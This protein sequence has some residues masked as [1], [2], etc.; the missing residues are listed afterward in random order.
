MY[1]V[2]NKRSRRIGSVILS[3]I[4]VLTAFTATWV[5]ADDSPL[6]ITTTSLP[7]G[8]AGEKYPGVQLQATGG[9]GEGY[10]FY[11]QKGRLYAGIAE[12]WVEG[13]DG[14]IS[15]TPT[16]GGLSYVTF[17]VMDSE[18]NSATKRLSLSISYKNVGFTVSNY[19]YTYDGEPHTATV[20]ITDPQLRS[21]VGDNYTVLFGGEPSQTSS[22]LYSIQV[23][24]SKAGY[25][26][27]SINTPLTILR[28]EASAISLSSQTV[29]YDGRQHELVPTVTL[30]GETLTPEQLEE[31]A[32]SV[33]VTY[34]GTGATNYPASETAPVSAGTYRVTA[35][36]SSPGYT[37]RTANATLTINAPRIDFE[38]SGDMECDYDGNNHALTVN[39]V[40]SEGEQI[41]EYVVTYDDLSTI[42]TEE[43][44][45]V[46]NA[47]T[48]GLNISFPDGNHAVGN[49]THTSGNENATILTI[50]PITVDFNV[51]GN[52][53]RYNGHDQTAEVTPIVRED[54]ETPSFTV[55]Y[56]DTATEEV[57]ELAAV[58][59]PGAYDINVRLTSRNYEVGTLSASTMV[60]NGWS[61]DFDIT[62]TEWVYDAK[63]HKASV[64]PAD[65]EITADD[66]T[67][68][69]DNVS[70][71]DTETDSEVTNA[72]TY[73]INITLKDEN[74]KI[75]EVPDVFL[76]IEKRPVNFEVTGN[77]VQYDG[78]PHSASVMPVIS[79]QE[80]GETDTEHTYTYDV[81][82][83]DLSTE[84]IV[85]TEKEV[86]GVGKY[87]INIAVTDDNHKLGNISGSA[88]F[89]I[90]PILVDFTVSE[91]KVT[92]DG[93]SH[94][95]EVKP[96]LKEGQSESDIPEFT[97]T[98][99][100]QATSDVAETDAAVTD[101]GIY[102]I[103]IEF[104]DKSYAAG[105]IGGAVFV[106]EPKPVDFVVTDN[107]VV[108]DGEFH[109]AALTCGEEGFNEGTDYTVS[110]DDK[111]T[112]DVE[113]YDEVS[114]I[115]QYKINVEFKDGNYKCG[116]LDNDT[117]TVTPK[118]VRFAISETRQE[119]DGNSHKAKIEAVSEDGVPLHDAPEYIVTYDNKATEDSEEKDESVTD[120]G[121]YSINIEFTGENGGIY[122][123]EI[124][125]GSTL[126]TIAPKPI[127]FEIKNNVYP[128][129]G[130]AHKASVEAISDQGSIPAVKVT[131]DNAA[132]EEV[133]A[134]AEAV[135]IGKYN[136]N[137][138]IEDNNYTAVS[139]DETVLY[140]NRRSVIFA[141]S[142]T[143]KEYN[144]SAQQ[145]A[146]TLAE[147]QNIEDIPAFT[148][149]Y[150]DLAT[151]EM[152][153]T[154]T[155][156][157]DAGIYGISVVFGGE[158]AGEYA[159]VF[160][161]Y[162]TAENP[163]PVFTI[164]P[165]AVKVIITGTE[166]TY[167]GAEHEATV[168][169][170]DGQ[171][172]VPAFTVT[173][174]N[175]ATDETETLV[176]VSEIGVYTI[177]IDFG[178]GNYIAVSENE[179]DFVLT[180]SHKFVV[181]TVSGAT[182]TYS[183]SAQQADVTRKTAESEDISAIPDYSIIY[184]NS[185]TE[186]IEK[187]EAVTDAG[188][189]NIRVE[190]AGDNAGEY[191]AVFEGDGV[192][193]GEAVFTVNPVEVR[194]NISDTEYTYDGAEHRATI[195]L[196]EGQDPESIPAYSVTYDNR[197]TEEK[198]AL[199][200]A[201]EIGV[202]DIDID[203][204]SGNYKA[205]SA[206]GSEFVLVIS[207]KTA[208]FTVSEATAIYSGE[209]KTASVVLK[210]EAGE[211]AANIPEYVI[212][213][214]N[215]A[216][217]ET[218]NDAAVTDAGIYGIN[219]IFTGEGS[220]EYA[221]VF[222]GEGVTD[223]HAVFTVNPAE[224]KFTVTNA[225]YLYDG[226]EHRADV[227][228][229]DGQD[230]ENIPAYTV[231]YDNRA[232]TETETLESVRE[233]GIYNINIDFGNGNYRAV[234]DSGKELVLVISR[235]SFVF[236]VSGATVTYNGEARTAS[237]M[238]K[239]EEGQETS[240]IPEYI[241]TY[242]N[243]ATTDA[244]EEDVSV[245][246]AGI[247]GINI[248]FTGE[249][250]SEY[251][252]SFEGDGVT[253]GEAVFTIDPAE[254]R[255]D[256]TGTEY[257]YD[258][259]GHS[260]SVTLAEGQEGVPTEFKVT[261]DNRETPETEALDAVTEIGV[262]DINIDLGSS[263]YKAAAGDG[264]E[265]VLVIKHKAA[266]FTVS[267]TTVTYNGEARTASVVLKEGQ[268]SADVPEYVITYD[269]LATGDIAET[270]ASATDAGIY[271][272]NVIFT[273]EGGDEYAAL[274]EGEGVIGGQAVFTVNPVEIM[275]A[276]TN[277]EYIYDREAHTADVVIAEGQDS[278]NVPQH[279]VTYDDKATEEVETL[280][281]VTNAGSYEIKISLGIN[282]RAVL[283]E[284]SAETLTI[285]PKSV[286]M[287]I[288]GNN[289]SMETEMP[290]YAAV[291]TPDDENF[292]KYTVTYTETSE[293]GAS[294]DGSVSTSGEYRI[295]INSDDKNYTAVIEE[296]QN[297]LFT[298]EYSNAVH[299]TVSGN[300]ANF[301]PETA[302]YGA[303]VT[304]SVDG[305]DGYTVSYYNVKDGEEAAELTEIT[306]PG[307]YNIEIKVTNEDHKLGNIKM[308]DGGEQV[309]VLSNPVTVTLGNGNS[310]GAQLMEDGGEQALDEFK[311][312]RM[313]NG[314]YHGL[315]AWEEGKDIDSDLS[316][317]FIFPWIFEMGSLDEVRAQIAAEIS[318]LAFDAVYADGSDAVSAFTVK[319]DGKDAGEWTDSVGY[320]SSGIYD[321]EYSYYDEY[322][323]KT[324]VAASRKI[325]V[326]ASQ[327]GDV[328]R[329]RNLNNGDAKYFRLKVI[330]NN[331]LLENPSA[332]ER[333]WL[334]RVCDINHDGKIDT[335]DES[336]ILS[337]FIDP[338]TM[339][340]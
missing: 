326:L 290:P 331:D 178:N 287:T 127:K 144:G 329:D 275:F 77:S 181:F 62:D 40:V 148:V 177:N 293:G 296:D 330:T 30:S 227:M 261:Y 207:H 322:E 7:R 316:A 98:Y 132:T 68:T 110:Y 205:V 306:E 145:A 315:E 37:E 114:E 236:M 281:S 286:N 147:G 324:I 128:Y 221:A 89:E 164:A 232:T 279:T 270:D 224:V 271:A 246:D 238:P 184:D 244:A 99:D 35:R 311:D 336:A 229:A 11:I 284:G 312:N 112:E 67:V 51:S 43:Y 300:R 323:K 199:E 159:A 2:K 60:V 101:A 106:I 100:N 12:N 214:D 139:D 218:E 170:A 255:F 125:T 103:N 22:G 303:I 104:V 74:I 201:S 155:A 32:E 228:P 14:I 31:R 254:V 75:G 249:N 6:E 24:I 123:P 189:Y 200:T 56:D 105:D 160:E 295:G 117:F 79:S 52:N 304:P 78:E 190:F 206:D 41:P 95:A 17:R 88:V 130:L 272:I 57:E 26:A 122:A 80:V 268:E 257:T 262:Y 3:V 29:D 168:T 216:T 121:I 297:T 87:N 208:V 321:M 4:L 46:I 309:F 45:E 96:V 69:Y 111:N 141:V 153:E 240:D 146:V 243:L 320:T 138:E 84:D 195:M 288:T 294:Y 108:Y 217:E 212:T 107:T 282:Y 9:S 140:I 115:G 71:E 191:A 59:V 202:Y 325:V 173:Y 266:I 226:E 203:F 250:G 223:G 198:E 263:N 235:E 90:T 231:T 1:S 70:T 278:E 149:V 197:A 126:L 220:S 172:D 116:I 259:N 328:N 211:E 165:K 49:I 333:L 157:T 274:F 166:Y 215:L 245:T 169:A 260:A 204:G 256:V 251:F 120:A 83:D 64:T 150:D 58:R 85:E 16:E 143:E 241:V 154:D 273:G 135:E 305:F 72:G 209:A 27:N 55:T 289:V 109:K 28:N 252:A 219:V 113:K 335:A 196:A 233:I 264:M 291:V 18:G 86:I 92:Y 91:E 230:I 258:G 158:N 192:V 81:T 314:V 194:F 334:Y 76:V 161:N 97:V 193:D 131:Y 13:G 292:T 299:F 222:E 54:E 327:A 210:A 163:A 39:A 137:I 225:K 179:N 48:Y 133:E 82:Y 10:K 93:A 136:I 20:T 283:T 36:L 152:A 339:F 285:S 332:D 175:Q 25:I 183:G 337:R 124:A 129:D 180:V 301:S 44:E 102:G 247:Y 277:A 318:A 8:R 61:A 33:T 134:L 34:T 269:N 307:R 340:Y 239:T 171:T 21:E 162:G 53:V 167:D 65:A 213:Y 182:V 5:W 187:D 50:R 63:P 237:V 73:K 94:K 308:E 253:D 302:T 23:R 38:V 176:S 66:Y 338:V 42:A 174:D 276:V 267:N 19:K 248:V 265:L 242:D 186:E 15:G 142:D 118:K 313:F 47:G 298:V 280:E 156:V 319:I 119:Y 151:T 188:I 317:Y 310:I 234:S 185:E